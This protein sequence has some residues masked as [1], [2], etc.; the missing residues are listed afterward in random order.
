MTYPVKIVSG[1]V[2][3]EGKEYKGYQWFPVD[4]LP[5]M[6]YDHRFQILKTIEQL[7]KFDGLKDI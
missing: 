2:R 5:R 3:E 1:K 4:K 6:A 7:G